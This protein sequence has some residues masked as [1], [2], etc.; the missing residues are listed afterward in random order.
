MG[1]GGRAQETVEVG[2]EVICTPKFNRKIRI[3]DFVSCQGKKRRGRGGRG[4]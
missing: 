3:V 4:R 1:G 2:I